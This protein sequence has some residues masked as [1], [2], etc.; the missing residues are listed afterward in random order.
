MNHLQ[1]FA[2]V[3]SEG[4]DEMSKKKDVQT[5]EELSDVLIAISVVAKRLARKI[6]ATGQRGDDENVADERNVT[7]HR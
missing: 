4:G 5:D 1:L 2:P 6:Q 7:D 3:N